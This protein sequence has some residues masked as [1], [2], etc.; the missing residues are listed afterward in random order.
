MQ[1]VVGSVVFSAIA[2]PSLPVAR[3]AI[4][5]RGLADVLFLGLLCSVFAFAVQLW[6]VRRTSAARA[7]ILMGTEPVWAVVVGV[8]VG[9]E[10]I[11]P[12]GV[13]GAALI[14]GAS[15][16]GQRDRAPPRLARRAPEQ[17]ASVEQ[18]PPHVRVGEVDQLVAAPR[19]H[20]AQRPE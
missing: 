3:R 9:G 20:G 13:A 12:V 18:A 5:C 6:A 10:A 11:G 14:V 8:A 7:S 4:G 2:G 1:L 17:A 16:A 15:Y 19:Q